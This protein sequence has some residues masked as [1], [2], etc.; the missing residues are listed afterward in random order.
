[1]TPSMF[2]QNGVLSGLPTNVMAI[3][4]LAGGKVFHHLLTRWKC[5]RTN[6][7]KI[8]ATVCEYTYDYIVFAEYKLQVSNSLTLKC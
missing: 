8:M 4:V 1:M 3:G 7:R 6:A 2:S 5:S